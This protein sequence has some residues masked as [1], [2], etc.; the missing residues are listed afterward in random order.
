MYR[1]MYKDAY[2]PQASFKGQFNR[3]D[4]AS[5]HLAYLVGVFM[6]NFRDQDYTVIKKAGRVIMRS[7]IFKDHTGDRE[8]YIEE[9]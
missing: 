8:Y 1:V 2:L 9:C 4:E 6:D 5:H 7:D 3:E